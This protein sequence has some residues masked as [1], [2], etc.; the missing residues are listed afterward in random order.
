MPVAVY[1]INGVLLAGYEANSGVNTFDVA[2][3]GIVVVRV[4]DKAVRV[5]LR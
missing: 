4:G 3:S 2:A 5:L 1:N